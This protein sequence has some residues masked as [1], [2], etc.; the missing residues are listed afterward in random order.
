MVGVLPEEEEAVVLATPAVRAFAKEQ[1]VSLEKVRGTGP[2]GSI[3]REDVLKASKQPAKAEDQYGTVERVAIR[4]VRKAI[5][6][7]LLLSQKTTASVTETDEADITELWSLR[8]R[9]KKALQEK[10]IHLTFMPFFMKA[11][12]HTCMEFSSVQRLR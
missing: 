10:G 4:G 7:N 12:Q 9:E 8:E 2:G 1:G 11:V 3:T 5:A 6:K